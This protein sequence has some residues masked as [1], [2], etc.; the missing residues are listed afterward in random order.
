MTAE[1]LLRTLATALREAGIP[2]MLTGSVASAYH[3]AGRA[4]MDLDLVIDPDPVGLEAFVARVAATGAYVS[5]EAAREALTQRTMFNVVDVESGWKADLIVRKARPF[6][7]E[8]FRRRQPVDFFGVGL[9]VASLE[10]VVLSKLEWAKLGGSARQ[11]ED[12]R[13]L[14]RMRGDEI[15]HAYVTRWVSALGLR[16]EWQSVSDVGA[17]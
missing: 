2:F 15:D 17:R 11:L 12:V 5:A 3:G 4:T 1:A 16:P 9:D 10:D 6:S 7:E 8:E 13:A 14:L